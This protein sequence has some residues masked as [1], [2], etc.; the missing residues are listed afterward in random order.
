MAKKIK[1]RQSLPPEYGHFVFPSGI[2]GAMAW[3]LSGAFSLGVTV[4][5]A[6]WLGNWIGFMMKRR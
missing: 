3:F 6:V 4:F 2:G 1:H 5:A